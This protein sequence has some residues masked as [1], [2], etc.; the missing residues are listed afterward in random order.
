MRLALTLGLVAALLTPSAARADPPLVDCANRAEPSPPQ[1]T[2]A[3][4]IVEACLCLQAAVRLPLV[5]PLAALPLIVPCGSEAARSGGRRVLCRGHA[6]E[7]ST[8]HQICPRWEHVLHEVVRA[9]SDWPTWPQE[10]ASQSGGRR[11]AAGQRGIPACFRGP[12]PG[13]LRIRDAA[14]ATILDHRGSA[15]S[16]LRVVEGSPCGLEF[17]TDPL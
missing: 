10:F 6:K 16:P 3:R 1:P 17:R 12:A 15:I 5:R 2:D 13:F 7:S 8:V 11:A 14:G 9:L 4:W